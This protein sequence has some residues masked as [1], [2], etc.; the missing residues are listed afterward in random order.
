MSTKKVWFVTGAS[1]GLGLTLVKKL[2]AEGYSVA[3]TSRNVSELQKVISTENSD[4]LP[5]EVD[6][7]NENSVSGAISKTVEKFGK[8]DVIVNNAGYGQLGTLEELT[9]KESRQNFDTNVF[10]SLNVIRKSMPYLRTQ[11]SG[12]VIN[13]ASIGGLTGD[14]PG[15]GIYCATKFAVV[16]FTEGLA[17]E[18]K[19]FG[20]N[21]TVVYP[22]YFRTEFLTGGSLRTPENEIDAYTVTRQIQKAHEQDINGNQPGDPE[23]AAVALIE[24]AAMENP[25]VH[26]VLGSDAFQMANN[27]LSTLQNEISDF[28]TL[29]IS[30]DY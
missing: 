16:G 2:L 26:L 6:L 11:K 10:G 29:S 18:A 1:K 23:K 12:L 27:K 3:A 8:L 20:V 17:A 14:F 28:K 30:T 22:G 15:W 9:D 5:L 24:L 25:P 13:I 19:E 7:V 4:F 21:A